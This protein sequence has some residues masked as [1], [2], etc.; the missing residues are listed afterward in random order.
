MPGMCVRKELT[1]QPSN[2]N[3]W[4][5]KPDQIGSRLSYME[6]ERTAPDIAKSAINDFEKSL[7]QGDYE[8][9]WANRSYSINVNCR[10]LVGRENLSM[11]FTEV[12]R[13]IEAHF[14]NEGWE[15]SAF[16]VLD[17]LM[18]P[19]YRGILILHKP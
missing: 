16:A 13:L 17:G 1:L 9:T 5:M 2:S 6:I 14:T 10:I 19:P 4:D 18:A 7:G 15:Y 8:F 3:I 12:K 11:V